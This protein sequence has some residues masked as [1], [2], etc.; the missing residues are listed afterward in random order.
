MNKNEN[1]S[2]FWILA[3]IAVAGIINMVCC[4]APELAK[5]G[6]A[7][8]GSTKGNQNLDGGYNPYGGYGG[9][10]PYGGYEDPYAGYGGYNPYD[11]YD[12]N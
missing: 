11:G 6:Q 5:Y 12:S 9:Y 8:G 7:V 3:V 10:N 1:K 4:G 2:A